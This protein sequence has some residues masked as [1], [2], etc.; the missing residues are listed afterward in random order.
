MSKYPSNIFEIRPKDNAFTA[1]QNT[2]KIIPVIHRNYYVFNVGRV[3]VRAEV[4]VGTSLGWYGKAAGP[5]EVLPGEEAILDMSTKNYV[6]SAVKVYN[7]Y[8]LRALVHV[9]KDDASDWSG[10]PKAPLK[11]DINEVG[12][13]LVK[14]SP[15]N[16]PPVGD[17]LDPLM[18]FF[19]PQ[20][21]IVWGIVFDD[22]VQFPS[23]VKMDIRQLRT[24][25]INLNALLETTGVNVSFQFMQLMEELTGFE[26]KFVTGKEADR[27]NYANYISLPY[28]S[29]M[30]SLKMCL[31]Q[32]GITNKNKL[33]LMD[34][35]VRRLLLLSKELIE[36]KNDGAVTYINELTKFIINDQ[37]KTCDPQQVFDAL[38]TTRTYCGLAGT[39]FIP[40]WK[41]ILKNP[42]W[43]KKAYN[44]VVVFST[45]FGRPSPLLYRQLAEENVPEPLLPQLVGETRNKLQAI[46]VWFW[47]Q[48]YKSPPKIGGLSIRFS[49]GNVKNT[50][51]FTNE[52][53][54]FV[55]G[56]VLL[57]SLKVWG[58][59]CINGLEFTSSDGRKQKCG[60]ALGMFER[61]AAPFPP[62]PLP[63]P[64]PPKV[65]D[66]RSHR[67]V[68]QSAG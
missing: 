20:R 7:D 29:C 65:V 22:A 67:V 17:K 42:F 58:D 37:Y 54:S 2:A 4:H 35:Q 59:G 28:Y 8:S 1:E 66:R 11:V 47:R 14:F 41:G 31:Y 56:D 39:G 49:N 23:K 5:V 52:G 40:Y 16:I 10:K 27:T 68:A 24:K 45:Y 33:N 62:L 36:D 18:D 53:R 61:E 64:L 13:T 30:V 12:K 15:G 9:G 3:P 26:K 55:F 43:K 25:L 38:A 34:E 19:F 21:E 46:D 32:F 51:G 57:V 60:C 48:N 44:D 63:L 6:A 50:G